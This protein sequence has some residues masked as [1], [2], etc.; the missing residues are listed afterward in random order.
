[1]ELRRS[2]WAQPC[3][4]RE[5]RSAARKRNWTELTIGTHKQRLEAL[6]APPVASERRNCVCHGTVRFWR[7]A[8]GDFLASESY[9]VAEVREGI[10]S[11][12][13]V[14]TPAAKCRPPRRGAEC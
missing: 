7:A 5:I 2:L 14:K 11:T 3:G 12:V 4:S 9:T 6:R 8:C 10:C 13:V 1:M